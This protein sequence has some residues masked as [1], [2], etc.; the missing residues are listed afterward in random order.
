ME[1]V[2]AYSDGDHKIQAFPLKEG[3]IDLISTDSPVIG[4][5]LIQAVV[6]GSV[7]LNFKSGTSKTLTITENQ[8][9]SLI[10]VKSVTIN[11]GTFRFS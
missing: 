11:T 9:Y 5:T 7:T 2:L 10:K 6:E 1:P 4:V 8:V 3:L